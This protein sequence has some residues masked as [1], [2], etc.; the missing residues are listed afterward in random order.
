MS[1]SGIFGENSDNNVF[2]DNKFFQNSV[3]ALYLSSSNNNIIY[4][5]TFKKTDV[6]T[7]S[8]NAID[9]EN[10]NRINISNNIIFKSTN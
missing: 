10:C 6:E 3:T 9:G 2:S 7:L 5:N 1:D 4:N 8:G